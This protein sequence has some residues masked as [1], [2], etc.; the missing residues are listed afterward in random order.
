MRVLF[1]KDFE[2]DFKKLPIHIKRKIKEINE[3]FELVSNFDDYNNNNLEKLSTN[4]NS[5]LYRYKIGNYRL[6]LSLENDEEGEII[7]FEVIKTRGEIYKFFPPSDK[8]R[9]K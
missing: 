1:T 2:K 7:S 6:G 5:L 8:K 3:S 9:K 4:D